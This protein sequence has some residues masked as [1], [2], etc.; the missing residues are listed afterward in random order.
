MPAG[1][2]LS[3]R[4]FSARTD[5]FVDGVRD[6]G[7][8]SRDPFNVEQVEVTKGPASAYRG[9]RLDRRPINL[10]TKAPTLARGL[11]A[12]RSA[13][14]TDDYKRG[15]VDVNQPLAGV[16]LGAARSG[17]NAMWTDAD[18][19]GR[20]AVENER[21]GV[22]P[23]LAFGLGHADAR[24]RSSY[25]H[26]DQDNLPDYGMPGCRPT[27]TCRWRSIGDQPRAGRLRAT[28][29]ASPPATTRTRDRPGHRARL[30]HDLGGAC[31]LRSLV[32][33]GRTPARLGHHRAPLRQQQRQHRHQPPAPVPRPERR[34]PAD[35]TRPD[36]PLRAPG[37]VDHALVAG[38][39]VARETSDNFARI[40]PAAPLADLFDPDP[41][42][43]YPGPITRTGAERRHGRLA[44]RLR[45]RHRR[46]WASTGELTGGLRWD[47]FDVDYD[48]DARS[49][50]RSR[51]STAT[52]RCVSWRAGVVY[53]P[54]PNGSIY[55]GYGTSFNPSAEGLTL[56]AATAALEPEKSRSLELGTKWDVA[57]AGWR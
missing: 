35:Q 14:G 23:S 47:R 51:R 54:R 11:R 27:P 55:A 40:G 39:E 10:A 13:R 1:D 18:M 20:D 24:S 8:Y 19:P 57:G 25:S 43:P 46:S 41:D 16:G 30:E 45:V 22:A 36:R 33:Y 9:P 26:L 48:S 5:I 52:T 42:A 34:D 29:T 56:S 53:K 21:W 28:S 44:G 6:F 2:N 12:A 4:G 49:P 37:R 50:A 7:G 15:T 38:V 31:T 3:I 32:R 17:L